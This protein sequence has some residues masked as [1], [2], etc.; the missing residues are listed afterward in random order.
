LLNLFFLTS[1][2]RPFLELA[3]QSTPQD[4]KLPIPLGHNLDWGKCADLGVRMVNTFEK[5]SWYSIR[6]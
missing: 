6:G 2:L 5:S 3:E 1:L 4:S